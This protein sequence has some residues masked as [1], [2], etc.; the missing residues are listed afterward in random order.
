LTNAVC[1]LA[2]L[3]YSQVQQ[4]NQGFQPPNGSAENETSKAFHDKAY[5]QLMNAKQSGGY[6]ESDV[7]AAFHLV[8]YSQMAGGVTDWRQSMVVALD[9]LGNLGLTTE[10]NPL[11]MYRSME[12]NTQIV[13][14]IAM[15]SD[16][17]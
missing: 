2:A 15:V 16:Y 10:E 13:V 4:S 3:Y 11:E 9:W 7:L 6:K 12:P 14:K 1:A 17:V 8:C 5:V